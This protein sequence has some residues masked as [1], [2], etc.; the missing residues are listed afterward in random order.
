VVG[1]GILQFDG[2]WFEFRGDIPPGYVV[3]NAY[4][5]EG[6]GGLSKCGGPEILEGSSST[7]ET[8]PRGFDSLLAS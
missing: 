7:S 4:P 3:L 6:R 2:G 1:V 5:W 8:N